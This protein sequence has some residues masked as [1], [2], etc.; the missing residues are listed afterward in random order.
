[1][2]L[3]QVDTLMVRFVLGKQDKEVLEAKDANEIPIFAAKD[4]YLLGRWMCHFA[5]TS[6]SHCFCG[7][8]TQTC[9]SVHRN[10]TSP[11]VTAGCRG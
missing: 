7:E 5:Y 10:S 6:G 11:W 2:F 1:V 3:G 4:R 9:L 8:G